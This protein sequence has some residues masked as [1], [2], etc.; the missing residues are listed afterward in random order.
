M[1]PSPEWRTRLVSK[2]GY[3]DLA[4][5]VA[6]RPEATFYD[7]WGDNIDP[8]WFF[9]LGEA[10]GATRQQLVFAN[11]AVARLCLHLV[12]EG[13]NRPRIAVETVEAWVR[14]EATEEQVA[15]AR[16][17]AAMSITTAYYS[18]PASYAAY[19]AAYYANISIY[20]PTATDYALQAGIKNQIICATLRKHLNFERPRE[21]GLTV[22]QRLTL[23]D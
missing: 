6:S 1:I 22:W 4:Q 21:K 19:N 23:E 15:K 20:T 14:G 10:G 9:L 5:W 2:D 13:E 7:L 12:P 3:L 16:V 8:K 11:C 17:N 18:C